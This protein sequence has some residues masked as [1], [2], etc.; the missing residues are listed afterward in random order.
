MGRPRKMIIKK[1]LT[2]EQ[3][4]NLEGAWI[5]ESYMKYPVINSNID[6]YYIDNDGSEKLLSKFT[7]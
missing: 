7:I 2:D 3:T 4:A 5:D 6:V 1:I